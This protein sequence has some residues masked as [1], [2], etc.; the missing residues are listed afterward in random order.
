MKYSLVIPVYNGEKT[1][2]PLYE[3]IKRFFETQKLS[4]EVI[5]VYDCGK[6]D[7]W[8]VLLNLKKEYTDDKF[9]LVKLSRNF[10][11]HNALICG[12]EYV[13]G[14][15]VITMDEDLQHAPEDIAKL[16]SQQQKSDF[17]VVYGKYEERKHAFFRNITSK[18]L[19]KMIEKGIPDIHPD[20]SA[21]R[22][23]KTSVAKS[24]I[25]MQN[26]YTFLDGYLAWITTN[27]SSCLVT[28]SERQGGVSA[29]DLKKLVSHTI[30][31]FVTF[32]NYPIRFLTKMSFFVLFVITIFSMYIFIRKILYNDFIVGYASIII[33]VGFGV[34][35]LMLSL[36]IIGEYIYRI[37][38]KTTKR[39]NYKVDKV[40]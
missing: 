32:S 40:L 37:N 19:K 12:F 21:F 28:H 2:K 31:I 10:G 14:D 24:T 25:D 18:I 29:Y 30:N 11:Q 38:L 17:D 26:S 8:N 7:S 13:T 34:G 4:Y 16:I 39:P 23:I 9:F 1:V 36:G 27:V 6:D 5:F 20:Y 15:F 22:L 35:L 3:R 33:A